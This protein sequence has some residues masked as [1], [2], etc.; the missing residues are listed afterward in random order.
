MER[1]A[2]VTRRR[3][4]FIHGFDPRG[5]RVYHA[6]YRDQAALYAAR[7]GVRVDVGARQAEGARDARWTVDADIDGQPVA[8]DYTFLNW[9]DL[10][11]GHLKHSSARI[12]LDGVLT[13]FDMLQSGHW[14][15]IWRAD[16][17]SA[18]LIAYPHVMAFL[19]PVLVLALS[20]LAYFAVASADAPI[21][22]AGLAWAGAAWGLF[23][24]SRRLDRHHYIYHLLTSFTDAVRQARGARPETEQR[25]DEFAAAIAAVDQSLYDEVLVVGH[26]IGAYQAVSAMARALPLAAADARFSLLTL[27]QNGPFAAYH[28]AASDLRR[29]FAEVAADARVV[30]TDVSSPHDWLCHILLD[31][32][33]APDVPRLPGLQPPLVLS[34]RLPEIFSAK[35][36]R[37]M[38]LDF[39]EF[40]FL[41][42]YAN[43]EAGVWDWFETTAGPLSLADRFAGRTSHPDATRMMAPG[44]YKT[45]SA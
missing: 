39:F 8:V 5:A 33:A 15:N 31:V 29:H 4:F 42:M 40:H 41:Y 37:R 11:S 25:L 21:W 18:A 12:L 26:S 16:R 22:A 3:V 13:W 35:T 34:A 30:W 10:A 7:F 1:V 43:E 28:P 45:P 32:T 17:G 20:G 36:L 23:R 44:R 6:K 14:M 24:L 27:G 38:R 2:T 9:G 19:M